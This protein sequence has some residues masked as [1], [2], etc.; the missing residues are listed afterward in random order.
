MPAGVE[1]SIRIDN[2]AS[3]AGKGRK[4]IALEM[5]FKDDP[6]GDISAECFPDFPQRRRP[7]PA[8]HVFVGVLV[9]IKDL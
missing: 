2:G 5:T 9:V 3:G 1:I 6:I 7:N 8:I 4:P